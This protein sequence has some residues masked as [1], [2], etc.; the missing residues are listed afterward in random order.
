MWLTEPVAIHPKRI[1]GLHHESNLCGSTLDRLERQIV[2]FVFMQMNES[3]KGAQCNKVIMI[4]S[5]GAGDAYEDIFQKYNWPSLE[6]S[7]S[8]HSQSR[9]I[10]M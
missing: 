1:I 5:D 9:M 2:R 3:Q 8:E 10:F 7:Y 6:V 4:V